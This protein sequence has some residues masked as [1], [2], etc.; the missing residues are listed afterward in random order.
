MKQSLAGVTIRHRELVGSV[1]NGAVTG[2][3]V[4]ALSQAIPGYDFCPTCSTMFPWLSGMAQNYEMFHINKLGFELISGQ[5]TTSSGRV[6]MAIDYDYDDPVSLT[7]QEVLGKTSTVSGPVWDVLRLQA[8]ASAMHRDMPYKYTSEA[9]RSNAIEPRTVYCGFLVIAIDTPTPN[10]SFDLWTE[11]DIT[12]KNPE[13]NIAVPS[14]TLGDTLANYPVTNLT[15]TTILGQPARWLSSQK[16]L[17]GS[18]RQVVPGA[19]GVPDMRVGTSAPP[20]VWDMRSVGDT[21]AAIVAKFAVDLNSPASILTNNCPD[22]D[23][24]CFDQAGNYLG[25]LSSI[26]ALDTDACGVTVPGNIQVVG[27]DMCAK[28]SFF[29]PEL[30]KTFPNAQYLGPILKTTA[31]LISGFITSGIQ[32]LLSMV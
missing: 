8:D 7:K 9:G 22:V 1:T 2:F 18:I 14:S 29:T 13:F 25:L 20:V 19:N 15:N 4:T 31:P 24:A 28:R 27:S 32:A 16:P 10:L 11:Y 3:A 5:A 26:T 6:A 23:A 17:V 21:M 30:R 12:F